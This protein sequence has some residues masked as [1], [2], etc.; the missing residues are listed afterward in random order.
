MNKTILFSDGP[1]SDDKNKTIL[2][3][4]IVCII[5]F[6]SLI[7]FLYFYIIAQKK[8]KKQINLSKNSADSWRA[9]PESGDAGPEPTLWRNAIIENEINLG[10]IYRKETNKR[11]VVN[12]LV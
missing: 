7:I 9:C 5:V 2:I 1:S 8:D 6:L 11:L 4:V 3:T 10:D 12:P